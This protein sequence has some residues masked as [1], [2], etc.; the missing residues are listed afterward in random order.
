[1]K[2]FSINRTYSTGRGGGFFKTN[3]ADEWCAEVFHQLN[4]ETHQYQFELIRS[5]FDP[6]RHGLSFSITACY[7]IADFYRKAGGISSKT[8][9]VSNFEKILIDCMCLPKFNETPVP[10]GCK[11]LNVDDKY[12]I[13][14]HSAK[15]PTNG[16]P[17]ISVFVSIVDLPSLDGD[18]P[19]ALV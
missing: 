16:T 7:P 3:A 1:L 5:V 17:W 13:D 6:K 12:I 10:Y 9:D 19:G 18:G 2:P 11:N 15:R 4:S 14:M 8:Q